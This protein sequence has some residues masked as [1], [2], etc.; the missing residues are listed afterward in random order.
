MR[1]FVIAGVNFSQTSVTF[2][3]DLGAVRNS[4]VSAR[5]EPTVPPIYNIK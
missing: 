2:A 5:L 3:G 1:E 4:G